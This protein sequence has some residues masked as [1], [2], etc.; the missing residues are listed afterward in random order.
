MMVFNEHIF[1]MLMRQNW[2]VKKTKA[3]KSFG[4]GLAQE[5]LE[6]VRQEL[7]GQ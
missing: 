1:Q 3:P 4:A 6:L 5:L 2:C 7:R